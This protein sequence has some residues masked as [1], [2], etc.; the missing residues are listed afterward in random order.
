MSY[1]GID[2]PPPDFTRAGD[3]LWASFYLAPAPSHADIRW[4]PHLA[5]LRSRGWG[6]APLFAGQ[7]HPSIP[8]ASHVRTAEQGRQDALLAAQLATQAGFAAEDLPGPPTIYLAIDG[9]L[10]RPD[11]TYV[12]A[13]CA[14]MRSS[15]TAYLPGVRC[16]SPVTAAQLRASD[17]AIMTPSVSE[18]PDPSHPERKFAGRWLT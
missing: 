9:P 1:A 13:W 17:L 12:N 7:Q 15:E 11:L 3:L 18:V 4:M 8:G 2:G 10:P 6:V 16:L 5:A 14:I